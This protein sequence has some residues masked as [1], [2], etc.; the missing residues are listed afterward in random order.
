MPCVQFVI[1]GAT[2]THTYIGLTRVPGY[3]HEFQLKTCTSTTQYQ[4]ANQ[5]WGPNIYKGSRDLATSIL[6]VIYYPL[7]G[8]DVA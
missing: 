5:G 7:A 3:Q 2:N 6:G 1:W 4:L 8:L